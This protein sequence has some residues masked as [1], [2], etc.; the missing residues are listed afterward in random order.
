MPDI[1]VK[2]NFL[3]YGEKAPNGFSYKGKLSTSS[4]FG[5]WTYYTN[6]EEATKNS[7]DKET[8]ESF[9]GYTARGPATD[10]SA[11]QEYFTMTNEGRIYTKEERR[12]WMM[13][14]KSGFMKDGDLAWTVMVSL[15]SFELLKEYHLKDQNDFSQIAV[16]TMNKVLCRM[17]IDPMNAIWW[18]DY[19]TNT[20]H[21]HMHITFLEKEHKRSKG[22][23]TKEEVRAVKSIFTTEL[24]ARKKYYE[25]FN[26]TSED[27]LKS[28]TPL[29]QN[30]VK[31]VKDLDYTVMEDI[32]NLY[33]KLPSSGRL[34]YGSSFMIPF[35]E[36]LDRIVS[37][38]LETDPIR[39]EYEQFKTKIITLQ[40]NLN[41][42]NGGDISSLFQSQDEKLRI[43]IAN[44]VLSSY[45]NLTKTDRIQMDELRGWKHKAG[46]E[47]LMNMIRNTDSISTDIRNGIADLLKAGRYQEAIRNLHRI[48][49]QEDRIF[50]LAAMKIMKDRRSKEYAEGMEIMHSSRLRNDKSADIY[51]NF[52]NKKYSIS[53]HTFSVLKRKLSPYLS[54][55]AAESIHKQQA[56]LQKEIEEYLKMQEESIQNTIPYTN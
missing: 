56:D 35:R 55:V 1:V 22:K 23:L 16:R 9:I 34:Q 25:L 52:A 21:P 18:E 5:K 51:M 50:V 49:L 24:L 7:I 6:R 39:N 19:H 27:A 4:L 17:G 53:K 26:E 14:S 46:N 3:Q 30:V 44:A 13:N 15:D 12:N 47:L 37:R 28:L 2:M 42:L 40:N 20:E 11:D 54:K 45:K 29:R 36:D 41:E 38:I 32:V 10:N 48:E 43:Q 33:T 8:D 31:S